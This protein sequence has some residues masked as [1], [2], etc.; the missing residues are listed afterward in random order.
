MFAR[1]AAEFASRQAV[2][3]ATGTVLTYSELDA[4]SNQLARWL[5]GKGVGTE[6]LVA[7]AI[8]RSVDLLTAIWAVA[9]TGGGYVPVDPTYPADRVQAMIED[10][11]AMLGLAVAASGDLPDQG[12]DW[13][14]LDSTE[15]A[16]AIDTASTASITDAETIAPV[17][18]HNTAYVIYTSG[19]T[20]R[21]KGVAVTH[22]GLANFAEEERRRSSADEYARVLGFASPSFDA[23]VLEYLL[24]TV[25]G[26]VLIYRPD[27][28]VGGPVLQDFMMRQAVTHTFLT[29]TV[30]STLE[31]AG[32]PALRVVYAGG[33]AVP[34][35]LRDEWSQMRRIQNLYGPTETTIG[36]TISEPMQPGTPVYLGGPINGV[37]L[38]ILDNRLKPVPV[39]VPGELYVV[40]NAVSRGY[41][42]HPA[43]TAVR[44][45]ANP[46][47]VPGD[48]MYRTGD[49]VRWRKG[50]TGE[51]VIEYS[52][53]SDDQV[54][55]RGL[56]IELGE[57]EA[58]MAS[59]QAVDSAVVVGVGTST[60]L[61][62]SGS[63]ATA[64]AG[65][66]VARTSSAVETIDVAELKDFLSE[67][68]P[69]HMVP[70]SITVLDALP[71]TPVGKLDKRA[72]PAPVIEAAVYVAPA[73]DAERAVAAVYADLLGRDQVSVTE[74][75][76]DLGGNSL[77]ATRV[78]ARVSDALDVEVSIRDVFDAP[79]ARELAAAVAGHGSA[80]PP[81]TVVDPRPEQVPLSYAQQRM[82]FINQFD[83]SLP[84]YNV[85]IALRLSGP[86][87]LDALHAAFTD[88]VDRHEVLRTTFPALDG[89]PYQQI[90]PAGA[91]L[92]W[93]VVDGRDGIE[94]A[95]STGF[96]VSADLPLRAR[97]WA[98]AENEH[99][100]AV[101]AHHIAA[102]GES[103]APLI[104]DAVIAYLARVGGR[105]PE[106]APLQV[107]FADYAIWQREVLGSTADADSVL[108]R[109]LA[110][111]T[112]R[113]AGLPDVLELPSDRPR[114]AVAS[115]RGGSVEFTVPAEVADRV[116]DL[117]A[118]TG[119]T[120][121][122]V[123][124]SALAAFLARMTDTE[125]IAVSTPVAGRGH[126][127]LD[128]LVG[129][130]VNTLVLRSVVDQRQSFSELLEQVRIG[131]L[132]AFGNADVPFETIVEAVDPV[133]SEA[134]A[135]LAQVMLTFAQGSGPSFDDTDGALGGLSIAPVE[136]IV[137]PAKLDL[138]VNLAAAEDGEDWAASFTYATD[139]FDASTVEEFATRFV[140]L[141]TELTADPESPIGDAPLI[142]LDEQRAIADASW[143]EIVDVPAFA[144]IGDAVAAQIAATPDAVALA[145]DGREVSYGEFGAR[146]NTLA[147]EL[148]AAGVG[149][150][151][152]V[153]VC[154][155]R[156]IEMVVAVHAV[157]AAGGQYVPIDTAAPADRVEYMMSTAGA[158]LVLTSTGE[159][160]AP[161]AGL[162]GVPVISV[163]ASG[164]V[165]ADPGPIT[166]SCAADDAA[167]TLF[168][169][170]STG[171]P[172]GVTVSHRAVLNRLWWG[173]DAFPW[174][175]PSDTSGG[176][177]V[178]QKTPYT[179]DVSVP[180][181]FGPLLTGATVVIAKPGGH[182]DPE[183]I[184]DLIEETA[185]TSV[186]FVPSMLSV[187]LDV[188]DSER[189]SRLTSLTWVFASGEA[190][191][192]A[193]VAA[194]NAVWPHVQIHN[195]FGPT[196]AAVE[197][198]WADVSDV[199][200]LVTIGRPVW[201]TS[202]V[203][204]DSR[205]QQVPVGVPGELYLGGVQ[206]A[207]GYAAQAGLTAERFVADPSG[208]PG[209]RLYRTGDL[210]RRG[211][212]GNIEYLGRTDFQV[213]LR[214]QRIEL[215][216][217]E[218]VLAGAPGVVHAAATVATAP[219]G[220]EHLVGYLS[221]STVD[222]DAVRD[223]VDAALPEYMR[224]S[225][226]SLIDDVVLGSAGKLDRKALPEPDFTTTVSDYV[227]PAT[228]I[229]ETLAS[230][231]A[232]VLGLERVSVTESFFALGGDS[233]M[234]I[235]L[236][237]A[238][239]GAGLELSPREIFENRTVRAMA[240]AVADDSARLPVLAELP[241]GGAGDSAIPSVVSWMIEL[242]GGTS[243]AVSA[244]A[245]LSQSAT[246]TA[247]KGLDRDG[248]AEV[249]DA[250][251]A[252]HPMLAARLTP[253]WTLT[254]GAGAAFTDLVS[255]D[256][257]V[258]SD[259][260]TSALH[261]AFAAASRRLDPTSGSLVSAIAVMDPTGDGRVVVV[262]HH[263]GVDAVSWP[264]L[265]EDFVTAWAQRASGVPI[266]LRPEVTS[267]RAWFG[268]I[269]AQK[270]E[271]LVEADYWL[272]RLPETATDLGGVL[273]PERDTM[274]TEQSVIHRVSPAVS[275]ALLTTVP[276]AFGTPGAQGSANDAL[277]GALARAV[278]SWQADRGIVDDAPVGFLVETHGRDEAI[279]AGSSDPHRADLTRTVGW[280]TTIAPISVDP[281]ADAA[282][283]VKAAKEERLG[284]P[285][286]GVGFGLLRYTE[287]SELGARPL[288]SIGFN[289]FGAG[290]AG[291]SSDETP[292]PLAF[293][294]A[295]DAP[296]FPPSATGTMPVLNALS[297]NVGTAVV[298]D[299][300]G[301]QRVLSANFSFPSALLDA[302][303]VA[304]LARRWEHELVAVVD[305]A[306]SGPGLS[307][308]DVPGVA[309]TQADLDTLDL[310]FPGA[311]V[312]PLTPLQRGLAFQ[313]ELTSS[314]VDVY[315][316]Q[317]VLTLG[318][319]LD[320]EKLRRA[321]TD[322]L[323]HHQVLRTGYV[324]TESG[325]TV[326]VVP[327][328]VDLPWSV[329]DLDE[330][331]AEAAA[332]RVKDIARRQRLLP[333]DLEAPPLIRFVVV[334]QAGSY[335]LVVTNHHIL[336]DGWSGPLVLADVLALY[337]TGSPF[338]AA[339]GTPSD[340]QR[341]G[342]G[343]YLRYIADTDEE[344]GLA[345]WAQV[346]APLD[347]ATLVAVGAEASSDAMPR[348]LTATLDAEATK[349]VEHLARAQGVTLSTVLQAAWAVLL[350]RLTGNRVV[351]FGETVSGR[352]ADLDGVESI[353]GLF[354]NTLPAVV[355]V[356]PHASVAQVLGRLQQAKVSVLDYQHLGLPQITALTG[357]PTLFNTLTVYESYPVDNESLSTAD[358]SMTGGLEIL[359]V[360]A[361]DATHYP[362]NLATMMSGD[363]LALKLK[364]LP[365]AFDDEQAAM[366]SAAIVR[367]LT[368]MVA[369]PQAL[370]SSISL[371][372]DEQAAGLTPV[373]G[374]DG[375]EPV[376]LADMFSGA[377]AA[378]P[379][380]V[381]VTDADGGS[382]T[383]AQLDERSNRLARAL[384]SQGAGAE[385]LIALA[386]PRSVELFTAVWAVAKTGG[387][388]VPI[389]P[390][391]PADRVR[392]MVEDSG[393]TF[394]LRTPA[395]GQLPSTGFDWF[396]LSGFDLT[397]L[398]GDPIDSS[399]LLRPVRTANTAY[400]IYT[401]GSTGRPKGVSV[402]HS[403]LANF[404]AQE[405]V[406]LRAGDAP[407]VLG[408]AS[409]SFDASVL[410]YLLA[411][412]NGGTLV[413]RPADAVGGPALGEFMAAQKITHTFLTPT[414]LSTV[415]AS[416]LP[417]LVSLAAGGEAVPDGVVEQWSAH[418][419]I[420]NLY[421]PTETTI[422][423]TISEPMA[424]GRPVRLGP[425]I[426]GVGLLVL[427]ANLRPAP[428]GVSGE[429]YV[430]GCALS[431]G[432]LDRPGLTAERFVANPFGEPGDRMYRTGDVVRWVVDRAG[433]L[434]V[435]YSGRSDDQV[436]LRGLRIELGE[437]EAVLA[438]HPSVE[439]AIV[440]STG[441]SVATALAGYVV[442]STD[443]TVADLRD[444]IATRLPAY[445]VPSTITLLDE[446]PLTPVGKLDKRALPEPEVVV[447]ES[448][449]AANDA[450]AAIAA[451]FADVLGIDGVSV[452]ASFF[453]LGGNSLSA[454]RVAGR[455]GEA[456]GVDV[457]V[458]EV[459]EAPSARDLAAAVADRAA[460]LA[461]VTAIVDRPDRIPLSFAQSRIWF[462]SQ[463]E[464][465]APTYNIPI[466]LKLT[467]D[468]DVDA[469]RTA[470][471]DVVARHEVLRTS[472]PAHEGEPYQRIHPVDSS[473]AVPDIA[474]VDTHEE[475][476][477]AATTGFDVSG[478]VPFRVR[479]QSTNGEWILLAVLHHLLGDGESMRPLVT[480][481]VTAY[482]SRSRG[483]TPQFT[484]LPVQFADFAMWQHRVLG[485]P[486][487]T[488]SV[489]GRQL[490][491]WADRLAG[492]PDVIDLPAD[493]PRPA[494]ASGRGEMVSVD[495]SAPIGAK[496][497]DVA[498]DHGVTPF[499]VVHAALAVLM[500]RLSATDDITVATPIAGR[501]QSVLDDLVGMFAGTLVLRTGVEPGMSFAD[502]LDEVRD[503][504]LEAFAH[505]DVPFEAVVERV[506][507]TRS[508]AFSPLAQ[509]MLTMV[510]PGPT[511]PV[512]SGDIEVTPLEPLAVAAQLDLQFAVAAEPGGDWRLN[513]VYATDLYDEVTVTATA[514]R[515]VALLDALTAS[516]YAPVGA[517]PF[518]ADG[519]ADELVDWSTGAPSR[520][521]PEVTLATMIDPRLTDNRPT[522][523]D[524]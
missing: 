32:L 488:G 512:F 351:A 482:L 20:G 161:V 197:V 385:T 517:A 499:M 339:A 346:V 364:Y 88:V 302:D 427:D 222:L 177:R 294:G 141:L 176:D 365:S 46:Y 455:V 68:L 343:D 358:A 54:K 303:A 196:E 35:A 360:D 72:L 250:V 18:I 493:R 465:E 469:L 384:I 407:V 394:G 19:S 262:I 304:D 492:V 79:S 448:V 51:M 223:V 116:F 259:E 253:A 275:E 295:V 258:G 313:S 27:D 192:P 458:R 159:A 227:P 106:F 212:D 139:L 260:Y 247:P 21:P 43:L 390:D 281:G 229:E 70:A 123:V 349:A 248:L 107:Q 413:Y 524:K 336:L 181:L 187:F 399:E 120:A 468:L 28:A 477:A 331:S 188:V 201:N 111:W 311:A 479:L 509:V 424:A 224:P 388:Y 414:V 359:G 1:A 315:V 381:A 344:A 314:Q 321:A 264:I 447:E 284:Q 129:M 481:M 44:F 319:S 31:S 204:L 69:S 451:V 75:F 521:R 60:G 268:A 160:P 108:G 396:D 172:K 208:A 370:T 113:L 345:A 221:P 417:D 236:A 249:V 363:L 478:S 297:V 137:P 373:G 489:I 102:D 89:V 518:L 291:S 446:L 453:D 305:A 474:I 133:R 153:G 456:L 74:S 257:A 215:G 121:F 436:K 30:L 14:R 23:S 283:A 119:A 4:R 323:A 185:A 415:D 178:I 112:E 382:L 175:G 65:Y 41:L 238:A 515:F 473:A 90:H 483:E 325:E 369:D 17:R 203:I 459:F 38:L 387:G 312:W 76:F 231:V 95:V 523:T 255:V 138:A 337:V 273:D 410:E 334:R 296:S 163:D 292:E 83:P 216:E 246:L 400:V 252:A 179:F 335:S 350:S 403:G 7:L 307:P 503:V 211:L 285:D 423:I 232:G 332:E 411:V 85:P 52:G 164:P 165:P 405:S 287:G 110:Y 254:A 324:R 239:R 237:S 37:G 430:A 228:T 169:S 104:T 47:G 155:P 433:A 87:D 241:G 186:H 422:G 514:R 277:L 397:E 154:L 409:P 105:A 167:Y 205:L 210:V 340:G 124:H 506:N 58:V 429:L 449:A 406:R 502:L 372:T 416:T 245:D 140:A 100:L 48:R 3:D 235:Q 380:R 136:D 391:Y 511:G 278:R 59:H 361:T 202:M 487:D 471:G 462:I 461:P 329:I 189:L 198:G 367:I 33:E 24:A 269:A 420:R 234:S 9:K 98:A 142:P 495:I 464:P 156:S 132:D 122:M 49:V 432:Y 82:W 217:I 375:T 191:P 42:D 265:I 270:T 157:I 404:G 53:R 327:D 45:V 463:L 6:S 243:S 507:P 494:V 392:A 34:A 66:V 131:D 279:V 115:E 200:A 11:G 25:S 452:T 368:S 271:R 500:S 412:R 393:A 442:A 148:T 326:A 510:Q 67:R 10:S 146:V 5:I 77:S 266:A 16:A 428:V 218:S 117:S 362:L 520:A 438:S 29:P 86:L 408:F 328:H 214:G 504:D 280:F 128:P 454:T 338:T 306:E 505:A 425:P 134:F 135:P 276:E 12:F 300:S 519:E 22:A 480:D 274:G 64:L 61:S 491:Q 341:T 149:P 355:D 379:A 230:I 401:S 73:T 450:E 152:A 57:I 109:Q 213:K 127:A 56:R 333:F 39:G 460:A 426:G 402:T 475:L 195:L 470:I 322:L 40:G 143:G 190:L 261:D 516:P 301:N 472:F 126:A 497:A 386:I 256:H 166:E 182:T 8:S 289:F 244:Y 310:R 347:D 476:L 99:V 147:R 374:G 242:T 435:E 118:T 457:S 97:I 173:L 431:R 419:D 290:R 342:F 354:I 445:M 63:V 441:G 366:L 180:E 508:Q 225:V 220:G 150:D 50:D 308:S 151:A 376:L 94:A 55:L 348:D 318:G 316:T 207:R 378:H 92:D 288:P 377:A 501:G 2:V 251:V 320:V 434:V 444:H 93:A 496:V 84:T 286:A 240:A 330:K 317:A 440:V 263:L 282:H 272:D 267:G 490:E 398:G 199:P 443:V 357:M 62:T 125:D 81:V 309:V 395:S 158:A 298:S 184:A 513:L 13:L 26:G 371:L 80:L 171:R 206:V 352:P 421:G 484:D 356:D 226:W 174:A 78:A 36:V 437:I 101:V 145:F 466:G 168:T 498:R 91:G 15:V 209:A 144:T 170:G 293:S 467:G 130:F 162:A 71:L 183:Y 233:I 485:D 486:S 193:T 96:D 353:V 418:T 219:G 114:P 299:P 194:T 103:M 439:T 389:D 383:Y 522:E